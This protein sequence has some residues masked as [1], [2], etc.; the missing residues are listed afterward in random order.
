MRAGSKQ[1]LT[2]LFTDIEGSTVRWEQSPGTAAVVE[3]HFAAL[4]RVT[5]AHGGRVFSS[6]GDGIAAAFGSASAAVEAAVAGQEAMIELGLVVRMGLHTGEADAVGSDLRGRAVNRAARVMASAHGGQVL[7]SDLTARL[8]ESIGETVDLRPLGRFRLRG[9]TEPERLWQVLHPLL[10]AEFPPPRTVELGVAPLPPSRSMLVGR[11]QEIAEVTELVTANERV[12]TLTGVGGVGKT[13]V[14]VGAAASVANALGRTTF[15]SLAA[16]GNPGEIDAA[17]ARAVGADPTLDPM[18]ATIA[19]LE[20]G[21][22]LLVLD[23]CEHLMPGVGATVDRLVETCPGLRVLATSRQR[24][25]VDGEHVIHVDPLDADLAVELLTHRI[26]SAGGLDATGFEHTDLL[27]I[28][29]RLDGIPLAIELV[30]PRVA[31]L[32]S[33]PVLVSLRERPLLEGAR[34]T[35]STD[36][37]AT[38]EAAIEWSYRLLDDHERRLLRNLAVF[39]DG[40]EYD[41]AAFV[42]NRCNVPP[43]TLEALVEQHMVVAEREVGRSRFRLLDTV[44][45]FVGYQLDDLGERF[46]AQ[47]NLVAWMVTISGVSTSD[48]AN[49]VVEQAS[50]RLERESANWLLAVEHANRWGDGATRAALCGPATA[51]F[52]LGRHDLAGNVA[53]LLPGCTGALERR[54]V[55][56]AMVVSSSGATEPARIREWVEE[57]V[58]ADRLEPTGL[59][60]LMLWLTLAWSGRV[61]E[62]V[63]V[64]VAHADDPRLAPATRDLFLAI[65]VLDH[66]S[67]TEADGDPHHLV[68]RAGDLPERADMALTRVASLLGVA[69]ATIDETPDRAVAL[70]RRAMAD[71]GSVPALT[72][73]T[74]P[75]S[76]S[77]LLSRLDPPVAARALL[78][79]IDTSARPGTFAHMIPLVYGAVVL[80]RC[81]HRP[82]GIGGDLTSG[83]RPL[84]ASV[85]MMDVVDL[86]RRVSAAGGPVDLRRFELD[87][88]SG[89]EE[90][91]EAP[92]MVG[93]S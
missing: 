33:M 58:A 45:A 11:V 75:G 54:A 16:V 31:A 68:K 66:F 92:A 53:S 51:F 60:G 9:L 89:L 91:S 24:L 72:R 62:A 49:V 10:P 19:L 73:V 74:L 34:S 46:R 57:I 2:F 55:L 42:A 65:A 61:D 44:R 39:V 90:L 50:R 27:E 59:G 30:A 48:P 63:S 78:D 47:S 7:I 79:Q 3:Q 5:E 32:G 93:P 13:R 15:V 4:D 82:A 26:S 87:V 76:A 71:V 67:L 41:A 83:G 17:I 12:V 80:D 29:R 14:A 43:H 81:G 20:D 28:C 25:G 18:A 8:L 70:V 64:C 77:R 84:S 1:T 22:S 36:R 37:Q 38:L 88:R 85:S 35:S 56:S 6:M 86:A 21:P 40:F 23:N 69:W 52:L